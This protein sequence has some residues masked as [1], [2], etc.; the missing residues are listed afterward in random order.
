MKTVNNIKNYLF[1]WGLVFL[2]ILITFRMREY[3]SPVLH[4]GL[5]RV[6]PFTNTPSFVDSLEEIEDMNPADDTSVKKPREPYNL[7]NGVL[8]LSTKRVSPTS[9]RCYESDFQTRLERGGT[10]R[11][12]TN[13]YKR[14][15]P[16]AC[17][18]PL[19]EFVLSYYTPPTI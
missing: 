13:N 15:A 4:K 1:V 14:A 5:E 19:H 17:S 18:A 8:P 11:Q 10:Y 16:D 9:Q 12:L 6:E 7:L 2:A 3:E